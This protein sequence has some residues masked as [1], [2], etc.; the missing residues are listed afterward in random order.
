MIISAIV[1]TLFS[2]ESPFNIK[3]KILVPVHFNTKS[4][5]YILFSA[6][7][8]VYSFTSLPWHNHHA[9]QMSKYKI[10]HKILVTLCTG[11]RLQIKNLC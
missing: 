10:F 9:E 3:S 5:H 4:L 1:N 6:F 11:K 2:G 7:V 8:S